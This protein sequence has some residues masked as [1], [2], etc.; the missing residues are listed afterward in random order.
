MSK[1]VS[2]LSEDGH[3]VDIDHVYDAMINIDP[4]HHLIHEGKF[5][6][7]YMQDI[8]VANDGKLEMYIIVGSSPMHVRVTGVTGGFGTLE[9]FEGS[10]ASSNGTPLVLTNRNRL[11]SNTADGTVYSEP[12]VTGDG[13]AIYKT[14]IIGGSGPKSTGGISAG[15]YEEY[16][17]NPGEAYLVRITNMAGNNQPLSLELNFYEV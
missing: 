14:L 3:V 1:Y 10:T 16:I 9:M 5:F 13:T 4:I 2:I 6:G 8:S 7:T 15:G 17:F 12:T 11:S